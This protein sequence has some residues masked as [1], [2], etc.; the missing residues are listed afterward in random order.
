MRLRTALLFLFI[1]V[2]IGSVSVKIP[3]HTKFT[4]ED[5]K[6][7]KTAMKKVKKTEKEW[8]EI[9][10]PEQYRV[11]RKSGT[12]RPFTG[13]YN[14]H[15]ENGM[16]ACAAC[17]NPLF[18]SET[19]Y[20]HGCGWP[21]FT[22]AAEKGSVEFYDDFSFGKKRIEVRCTACGSHLG[23]V[24]DDGPAPT[25]TRFCINSVALN[26][27]PSG[28]ET[29]SVNQYQAPSTDKEKSNQ[30]EIATFAAGCFWGV[31]H[32]FR[33]IE[34]VLSTRV[35]YTGGEV[36]NPTYRL[37]C[38]GKT[39]HA[40]SVEMT[41]DPSRVTY[42]DLLENFF[43]LHD[44]TQVN[45]QGPDVGTQYRS[46]IF[47]HTPEQ[48]NAAKK[49]IKELENSKRFRKPITTQVVP[50]EEFYEAED[51]HQQYYEKRKIRR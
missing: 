39:G 6:E 26:F 33:Q 32:K 15:F 23:H 49:F 16:Y 9:L 21:S 37:V 27:Q 46:V 44:P 48:K 2:V 25:H 29:E 24:F 5:Q 50:V 35:G 30:K 18:S 19:K 45:R 13:K 20:D 1:A 51:Y 14:L 17:G 11:L 40:E 10:T 42:K 38:T 8:K 47:Y 7:E 43:R 28:S 4:A 12:E 31:E 36:K 3:S 34:G 22:S 41:F